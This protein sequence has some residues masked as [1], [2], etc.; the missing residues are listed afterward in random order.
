MQNIPVV[1][2]Q[3]TTLSFCQRS[4]IYNNM[5]LKNMLYLN[6]EMNMYLLNEKS[7]KL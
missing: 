4:I 2:D 5:E 3:F 1:M 6:W 7:H